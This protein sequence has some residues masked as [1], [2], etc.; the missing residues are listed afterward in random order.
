MKEI[1]IRKLEYMLKE[2]KKNDKPQPIF[3]LG[4]GASKTGNIPLAGEIEKDILSKFHDSPFINELPPES[5][6]Y[7]KLMECL[8]PEQRN[9]LLKDYVDKGKINVTHIYLSQLLKEGFADYIL[10]VN[11]DNLILRALALFNIFPATHDL[12]ILKDLTTTVPNEKSVIYLHGQSHGLWL[13]NTEP[14]MEK[15]KNIVPKIFDS[16]K[17]KRP[18]IFIGYSG[19]D[20]VFEHI[21]NLG[22][23]DNGLYWVAYNNEDPNKNVSDFLNNT[24]TNSFLIKGYDADTFMLKLN[25]SLG[26]EQPDIVNK[27]F[28]ALKKSLEEIVDIEDTEN[29]KSIKERM[30]IALSQVSE[31]ISIFE[32]GKAIQK[33]MNINTEI[34]LLRKEIVNIIIAENYDM[35]IM[36][37]IEEKA[38]EFKDENLNSLLGNLFNN[39]GNYLGELVQTKEGKEADDLFGQAFEKYRKAVEI[40]SD[41]HEAFNNW[42]NALG[43]LAKT[44]E[45]KEA[46]DLFGQAFEKFRKAIEIKPDMHE[47]F[48]N[49][50]TYLGELAKT[51]EGKEA[52]DLFGQAFEKFRKAIEIKP[53]KHEA[54]YNWGTILGNLARTKEGKEADDL[55]GQ[56]FEKYRKAVEI[57]PDMH[58]AFYGWGTYLGELAKTKEGKKAEDLYG[59]AFEKYRKAVEIKPDMHEAFNSWGSFLT[60]LAKTKTGR[61]ADDLYGQAF[62]KFWKAVDLGGKCYNLACG[63]ALKRD[64]DAAFAYLA[65]SL[66]RKE[67]NVD[68]V[69]N[70]DDWKRYV[71]DVDFNEIIN[72]YK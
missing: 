15:V 14:E 18:W 25:H 5:K 1:E 38:R 34:E 58:E 61:E 2:A 10:T 33:E 23:F 21:K 47:A 48:S 64:K 9:Q 66:E 41:K 7:A 50:G 20:P 44:K 28:T 49:W 37:T 3:F 46:E 70:D 27:P 55:F 57:K 52:E 40:K 53:D 54:F 39:W 31:A 4:A 56:A 68:F 30:N 22:R 24:H 11:F 26:L 71:D 62:E 6:R 32:E 8:L 59:Q 12:A 35:N 17:N 69:I 43:N 29:L 16:I 19:N 65:L 60:N 51:K 63:Y 45:G 67:I 72:K 13:L 42:G 36:A